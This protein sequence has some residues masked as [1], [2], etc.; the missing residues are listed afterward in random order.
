MLVVLMG[1]QSKR[2]GVRGWERLNI[3]SRVFFFFFQSL[4]LQLYVQ[5]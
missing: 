4:M 1:D 3:V 2:Y 5:E